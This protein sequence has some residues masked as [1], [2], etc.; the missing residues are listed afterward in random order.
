MKW[1][2]TSPLCSCTWTWPEGGSGLCTCASWP[3]GR[4]SQLPSFSTAWG[5]DTIAVLKACPMVTLVVQGIALESITC[6]LMMSLPASG[7]LR[8]CTP[9]H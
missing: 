7:F 9:V 2:G 4:H 3:E 8:L 6:V 5:G 1:A